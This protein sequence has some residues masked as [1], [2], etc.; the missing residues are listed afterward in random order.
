ML[1]L[2]CFSGSWMRDIPINGPL[3]REKVCHFAAML[4]VENFQGSIGW[5]NR[6]RDRYGVVAKVIC[7]EASDAPAQSISEWR[8]G[9]IAALIENYSPDNADEAG[10]FY[11]LEPQKT[12]TFKADKC[13]GGKSS[14]QRLTA[15]FCCNKSGTEKRKILIIGKSAKPRC[16]KNCHSLPC[17][18]RANKKSWMTQSLFNDWLPN[19]DKD[20]KKQNRKVLLL[21]DNCT[22]HNDLPNLDF[23]RAE[24]F[25]PNCTS[26][27]QPLDQGIIR[28]VKARYRSLLLRHILLGI[29][30][31]SGRK[32]NVKEAIEMIAGSWNEISEN[33]IVNCWRHAQLC[34][35][36]KNSVEAD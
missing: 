22:A 30:N 17:E 36:D 24:Y 21:I 7:G 35:G 8:S 33:T 9:E 2:L 11:Q 28:A 6:F 23:V 18:Y 3:L 32:P 13:V 31:D 12:S 25:P 29:E 20:M 34:E 27:L 5:L 15:P 26:V 10:I 14:K 16:F 4:E 19:F 1:T